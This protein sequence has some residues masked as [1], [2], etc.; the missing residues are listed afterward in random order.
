MMRDL[1]IGSVVAA[2]AMFLWGFLFWGVGL[3]DPFAHTS[4][5]A[6]QELSKTLQT[7]L[8]EDGVYFIP[9]RTLESPE[10]WAKT[11]TKGPVVS[12]SIMK[13]GAAPMATSKL[14]MGFAHMLVATFDAL[15]V[16]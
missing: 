6:Q 2:I 12:I 11:H 15:F 3:I 5:A 16:R 7:S 10:D 1:L 8:P 13:S 14:L 9:D 4:I